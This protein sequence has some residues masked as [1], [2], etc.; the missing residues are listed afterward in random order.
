MK[1]NNDKVIIIL[2]ARYY[3]YNLLQH[4]FGNEPSLELLEV[5]TNEHTIESLQVLESEDN[6]F[7]DILRLFNEIKVEISADPDTVLDK[8]K[9][10]YTHLMIGPNKLPAP[11]WESVYRSK[12]RLIFQ[13]ST[14]AVRRSYLK[15]QFLPANYPHEADDHLALELDFMANL[16]KLS[17]NSFEDSRFDEVVKLLIDQKLFLEKHLLVWIDQFTD[18]TQKSKTHYFYPQ[19]ALLTSQFLR[20]DMA[21]I[22]ELNLLL[23]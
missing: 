17:L 16:A 5:V 1:A 3:I 2:A 4:V 7:P 11:P 14:L 12:E 15:Y 9:T 23:D 8:L 13:E 6:A 22:N 20:R 10:E 19:I 18:L 21:V